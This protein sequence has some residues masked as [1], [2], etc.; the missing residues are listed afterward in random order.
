MNLEPLPQNISIRISAGLS[1]KN[2]IV[3]YYKKFDPV[4]K[5]F[6]QQQILPCLG[7]S[8]DGIRTT[9][10]AIISSMIRSD[11]IDTWPG[12][13]DNLVIG[14]SNPQTDVKFIDGILGTVKMI[15]ED[16]TPDLCDNESYEPILLKLIPILMKY[17]HHNL[18][19][20]KT[21]ALDSL[22]NFI[23][24]MPV[25]FKQNFNEFM[26]VCIQFTFLRKNL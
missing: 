20:F 13:L 11:G 5:H 26:Q 8:V 17:L 24:F 15:C 1:L 9:A 10:G 6:I 16:A 22:N 3:Q 2:N 21:L 7:N 19:K 12:L 18:V 23:T 4:V 14:L 25:A